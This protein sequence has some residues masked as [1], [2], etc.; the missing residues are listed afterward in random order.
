MS[1][2]NYE[3]SCYGHELNLLSILYSLWGSYPTRSGLIGKSNHLRPIHLTVEH[4]MRG[5]LYDTII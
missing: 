1:S 2:E 4:D 5:S 3:E